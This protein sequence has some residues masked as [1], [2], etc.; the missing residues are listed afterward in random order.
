MHSIASRHSARLTVTLEAASIA[1]AVVEGNFAAMSEG[2]VP[3]IM[4]TADGVNRAPIWQQ[5]NCRMVRER[6]LE[7][8][9]DA[10]SNL[11]DFKRNG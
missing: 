9:G 6:L 3:E 8:A 11:R 5:T 2:R 10:A 4:G 7:L 1:H